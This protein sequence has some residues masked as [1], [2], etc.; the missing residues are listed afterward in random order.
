MIESILIKSIA[1]YDNSG[2]HIQELKKINFIYGVNGS[3]KTTLTKLISSPKDAIFAH[4]IVKW[5]NSLAL[6]ALVYNKEFRDS[7]FGKGKID[8]VFTLGKATKAET[9]LIERKTLERTV[10]KDEWNKKKESLEKQKELKLLKQASFKE[11][12]WADIYKK[13]ETEFKEAFVGY[14]V[15][16]NFKNN[17]IEEFKNT[18]TLIPT[19]E[20][21]RERA[22]TIFGKAPV[23]LP[24]ISLITFSR[25][26]EIETNKV[27]QKKIVGKGDVDIAKLIQRLNINDWVN[28]GRKYIQDGTDTCPFCQGQTINKSFKDQLESYFDESFISDTKLV[29]S[30]ADEYNVL[31]ANLLNLLTQTEA[32]EKTAESSKLNQESFSAYLKTFSAQIISNQQLIDNKIKEPS[33]SIALI[34]VKEQLESI[35]A[36]IDE[37]NKEI[38]KHNLIVSNF[39]REKQSLIKDVWR[40]LTDAHKATIQAFITE[41]TNFQK[42]IDGIEKS[43]RETNENYSL[44]NKEIKN[45]GK[46]VTSVQPSIDQI[47]TTLKSF[48]FRNFAI[49]AATESN[50][51]QIQ[52]EDGTIA[53]ATMSEGE[54]T[55]ITFLYFL[56]LTKGSTTED[57]I[58]EDRV[59]VVDDPISSLDSN[60]LFVVSSLLKEIIK[61]IKDGSG[62]IKQL[63]LLTHNVYFHKEVSFIDG[64]T[65]TCKDTAYWM[66]R[67]NNHI[68]TIQSFG[69]ANPI[70]N[71]YEL[72]W[73]ELKNRERNSGI[74]IQNTMRRIIE[75]YFKML[76]SRGNDLLI[77]KFTLAEEQEICRSLI[78]WINDGSHSI[79]DDLF[80]EHA[81]DTIDRY[82][83]VFEKI[84][85]HMNHKEH[86][87]MMMGVEAA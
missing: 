9:E 60:V 10:L 14:M 33:R 39:A 38:N 7:N 76:G 13:H 81:G 48:G 17:L 70:Q 66:L 41:Q 84:F 78:C 44:L 25:L 26:L 21:L 36:L 53:E 67:R 28:E 75:N 23:T 20:T 47:N 52:R 34:S 37:A 71:S 2:V 65:K 58:S 79:P 30:S 35:S 45:L 73:S 62:N 57:S 86:F 69:M 1:T 87:N 74:T 4:S 51:Y 83:T 3:G 59:L 77:E 63:I 18:I 43:V 72:L 56:Q 8:G 32:K 29:K 22:K 42:G 11:T 5:K 46:A 40:F 82:F 61:K 64:R 27:W 49:V 19:Y 15:K 31:A 54:I 55:F 16:E 85:E 12:V 50:K 68:T 24:N 6:K 80:V